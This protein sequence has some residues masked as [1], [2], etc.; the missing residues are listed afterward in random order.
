MK[1]LIKKELALALHPTLPLFAALSAMLL[2]PNY[3]FLVAFFYTGL[4]VFF[5]CLTARENSDLAFTLLLPVSRRDAVRARIFLAVLAEILQLLTAAVFAVLHN[6]LGIG[7]NAVSTD[8]NT[9]LFA[10]GLVLF[11]V[12]N[13]VF[14]PIYY[15]NPDR[16]GMPFLLA[17]IAVF[18]WI[19]VEIILAHAVPF[20]RDMLDTPDPLFLPEKLAALAVGFVVFA[21]L[22]LLAVHRAAGNLEALDIKA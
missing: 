9:A 8:A 11:G 20:C 22:T 14:F 6:L 21:A 1:A 19:T 5:D 16:V 4:G 12:F 10:Y 17:S 3:P 7:A 15:K 18:V 2:I 13:A